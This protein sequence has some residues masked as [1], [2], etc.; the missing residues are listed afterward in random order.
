[1]TMETMHSTYILGTVCLFATQKNECFIE[2]W[3][4][5]SRLRCSSDQCRRFLMIF[6]FHDK[7]YKSDTSKREV[8][9]LI[10]NNNLLLLINRV[11]LASESPSTRET[12]DIPLPTD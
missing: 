7:S 10:I 1:M 6:H 4:W 5:L 8:S 12:I 2:K 9:L 11:G 3:C